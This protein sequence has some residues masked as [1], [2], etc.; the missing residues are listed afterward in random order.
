MKCFRDCPKNC[1]L[2]VLYCSA[3]EV[4][5]DMS[6]VSWLYVARSFNIAKTAQFQGSAGLNGLTSASQQLK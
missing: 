6:F 2:I 4:F 5:T 3:L 1:A